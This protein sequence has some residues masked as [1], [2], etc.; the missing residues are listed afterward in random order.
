MHADRRCRRRRPRPPLEGTLRQRLSALDALNIRAL[1]TS[2]HESEKLLRDL[3]HAHDL[4]LGMSQWMRH[5]DR[6]LNRMKVSNA[7]LW[8]IEAY[9]KAERCL[10]CRS[11]LPPS[12]N[13]TSCSTCRSATMGSLPNY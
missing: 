1:Y 11:A 4:I 9:P 10:W 5:H 13:A 8:P 6:S 2:E 3:E 7:R 12:S